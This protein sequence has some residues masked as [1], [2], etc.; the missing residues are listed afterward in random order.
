MSI[1]PDAITELSKSLRSLAKA[2]RDSLRAAD[3][4][5]DCETPRRG[6]R[7]GRRTT[8]EAQWSTAAEYR[9]RLL[10][11]TRREAIAALHISVGDLEA[12]V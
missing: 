2:H 1:N 3:R 5:L 7:G 8:L 6:P 9:D 4:C 11:S 10:E 12:Q